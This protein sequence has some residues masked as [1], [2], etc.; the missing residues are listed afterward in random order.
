ML[1]SSDLTSSLLSYFYAAILS[2]ARNKNHIIRSHAATCFCATKR[3][4]RPS[5]SF[6]VITIG[7]AR[8]NFSHPPPHIPWEHKI[9]LSQ[10]GRSG[11]QD[12]HWKTQKRCSMRRK[13]CLTSISKLPVTARLPSKKK[14]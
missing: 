1:A 4:A 11:L 7:V 3:V 9:P 10:A 6:V 14:R 5:F 13:P 2:V 12:L 8:R